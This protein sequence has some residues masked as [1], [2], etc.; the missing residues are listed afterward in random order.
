MLFPR[1]NKLNVIPLNYSKL[2]ENIY[3][4]HISNQIGMV[5]ENSFSQSM[6]MG[7]KP[8]SEI[9]YIPTTLSSIINLF[10]EHFKTKN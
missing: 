2:C 10:L 1:L 8:L 5:K 9:Y 3:L 4:M 6:G 7:K